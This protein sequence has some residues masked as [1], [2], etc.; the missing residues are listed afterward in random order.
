MAVDGEVTDTAATSSGT[1]ARGCNFTSS[2]NIPKQP[3]RRPKSAACPKGKGSWV[4]VERF[5]NG[6]SSFVSG[7]EAMGHALVGKVTRPGEIALMNC[8]GKFSAVGQ[9]GG[10]IY[11][12]GKAKQ[13]LLI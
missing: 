7:S 5:V 1:Q 12:K 13:S 2:T 10:K 8:S 6:K 4:A 11:V 9:S 3:L